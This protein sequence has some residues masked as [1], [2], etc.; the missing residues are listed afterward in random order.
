MPAFLAACHPY[1]RLP[2]AAEKP[3][4]VHTVAVVTARWLW[5]LRAHFAPVWHDGA[6]P[7]VA[8]S[9]CAILS[10]HSSYICL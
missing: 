1:F 3:A 7:L 5:I 9:C 6:H 8:G 2:T 10:R 4:E